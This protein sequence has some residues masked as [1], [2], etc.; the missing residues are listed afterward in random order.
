MCKKKFVGG[1]SRLEKL[2]RCRAIS[3]EEGTWRERDRESWS[4]GKKKR[5]GEKSE[6]D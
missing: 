2:C 6:S 3:R 5:D 4:R 1:K